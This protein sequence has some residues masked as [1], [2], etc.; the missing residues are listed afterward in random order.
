MW[1]APF[2]LLA[3][4][5]PAAGMALQVRARDH[6]ELVRQPSKVQGVREA[7]EQ[8]AAH[9][10]MNDGKRGGAV[11]DEGDVRGKD[12]AEGD[13]NLSTPLDI[14]RVGFGNVARRCRSNDCEQAY[15]PP[16]RRRRSSDQ[17]T[18]GAESAS[19]SAIRRSSSERSASESGKRP[20]WSSKLSHSSAIASR[21]WAGG[22]RSS[23]FRCGFVI[24]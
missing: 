2:R 17:D 5:L 18:P 24:I 6:A 7:A 22:R 9:V 19:S 1:S 10:A 20:A 15:G 11:L 3:P 12:I 23:S 14:P 16:S 4:A 21:R 13:R 8:A